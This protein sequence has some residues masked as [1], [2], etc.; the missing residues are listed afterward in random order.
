M[1]ELPT[2]DDAV[3][4][5]VAVDDAV[6][7]ALIGGPV[8]G[9]A[10]RS[11]CGGDGFLNPRGAILGRWMRQR[12]VRHAAARPRRLIEP[13]ER[14][15]DAGHRLRIPPGR[16]AVSGAEL[17]GFEFVLAAVT[18]EEQLQ[19]CPGET[20]QRLRLWNEHAEHAKS[21]AERGLLGVGRGRVPG[22][23]VPGLMSEHG[24]QLGFVSKEREDAPRDV[25]ESARQREGVH[26]G[27]I[28]NRVRPRQARPL[29]GPGEA[30]ADAVHVLLKIRVLVDAHLPPDVLICL[31]AELNLLGL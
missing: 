9:A 3:L 12:P 4:A 1:D 15:Q 25:D 24:R 10:A 18:Q 22:G 27:R 29:G 14:A 13:A 8:R 30:L 7:L 16:G 2:A 23:H 11:A 6:D 26:G 5:T 28:D 20:L 21:A 19:A 31:L 17:V